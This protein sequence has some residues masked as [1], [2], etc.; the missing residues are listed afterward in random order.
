METC[1]GKRDNGRAHNDVDPPEC[2]CADS[3]GPFG[4]FKREYGGK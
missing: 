1:P 2:A 3:G 4:D